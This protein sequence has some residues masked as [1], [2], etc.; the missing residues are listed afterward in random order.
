MVKKKRTH[1]ASN[2]HFSGESPTTCNVIFEND[3][4]L[5][6]CCLISSILLS[7]FFR[8]FEP[9]S[10]FSVR[11]KAPN[12]PFIRAKINIEWL[13]DPYRIIEHIGVSWG[14]RIL[15]VITTRAG[16]CSSSSTKSLN[17]CVV[18]YDKYCIRVL[19]HLL[20]G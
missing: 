19:G 11:V 5:L 2:P 18:Y 10:I 12:N 4:V 6:R 14:Y 8:F 20:W 1:F 16:H 13:K 7:F 3:F 9:S 17:C 15:V